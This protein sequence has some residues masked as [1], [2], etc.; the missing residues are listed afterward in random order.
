MYTRF[1]KFDNRFNE[2]TQPESDFWNQETARLVC[3]ETNDWN[4][5][6]KPY[7]A[8][9]VK[10]YLQA[11]SSTLL[12]PF[13]LQHGFIDSQNSLYKSIEHPNS[14]S[15]KVPFIYLAFHGQ[16]GAIIYNDFEGSG[17]D[18]LIYPFESSTDVQRVIYIGACAIFGKD[19][20]ELL[21]R[22]LL[23]KSRSQAVI[24]YTAEKAGWYDSTIMDLLFIQRFYNHSNPFSGL[25]YIF[26]SVID[27][28]APAKA[29]GLKMFSRKSIRN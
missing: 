29:I 2:G 27:D 7:V 15:S 16:P 14:I 20:G 28:F 1:Q 26:N 6:N 9:T 5:E 18:E 10:P 23:E 17:L 25:D 22:R 21:A 11:M 8:L 4:T 12:H 13:Q 24:G 19:E 3:F